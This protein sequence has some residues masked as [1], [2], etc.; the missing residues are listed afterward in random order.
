MPPDKN[1]KIIIEFTIHEVDALAFILS[2]F[3]YG[4]TDSDIKDDAF[5]IQSKIIQKL[6]LE[7]LNK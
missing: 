5:S 2:K 4:I 7:N 3:N 6:L 1:K